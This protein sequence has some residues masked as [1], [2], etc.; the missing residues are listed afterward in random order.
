MSTLWKIRILFL[1]VGV[2]NWSVV[3]TVAFRCEM[4]AVLRI[5]GKSAHESLQGL[6]EVGCRSCCTVCC[7]TQIWVRPCATSCGKCGIFRTSAICNRNDISIIIHVRSNRN[8][9]REP[10]LGG[11]IDEQHIADIAP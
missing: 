4:E 11:L 9:V 5:I 6:P 3:P 8:G 10:G 2:E 7:Q 1:D